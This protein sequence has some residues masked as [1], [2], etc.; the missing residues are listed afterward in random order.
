[1]IKPAALAVG[2]GRA[3][4]VI[5][6]CG[7]VAEAVSVKAGRVLVEVINVTGTVGVWL[8]KTPRQLE[9]KTESTIKIRIPL[10][11]FIVCLPGNQREWLE[12]IN[13]GQFYQPGLLESH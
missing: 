9:R 10:F 5:D 6:G 1:M 4:G 7:L 13:N 8:G 2:E 3:E 12:R 11:V